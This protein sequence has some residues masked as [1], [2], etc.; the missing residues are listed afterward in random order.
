MCIVQ[1]G[2]L[3]RLVFWVRLFVSAGVGEVTRCMTER[4]RTT[5]NHQAPTNSVRAPKKP[6][7]LVVCV[8]ATAGEDISSVRFHQ[9]GAASLAVHFH[10]LPIHLGAA[11]LII[12]FHFLR[13]HVVG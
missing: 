2:V 6:T 11:S 7:G 9:G 5:D 13:I 8:A 10:F 3:Y 12:H 4:P 1:G